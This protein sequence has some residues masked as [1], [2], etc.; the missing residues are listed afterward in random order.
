MA[1]WH[2]VSDTS[3]DLFTLEGGEGVF[4]FATIPFTIR[5]GETE[6]IDDD[7]MSVEEMLTANE[8]H[9]EM[10]QT[11]CPS[12]EDWRE[13]FEAPG[14]VL[15]FTISSAL[16]GSYNSACAAKAM[17]LEDEP[18]KQIA[19]IDSKGTG[20]EVAAAVL[21]ARE[22][23]LAGKSFDEIEKELNR[24]VEETHI[25]FALASYRNLIKAGRVSR[26]VGFI[27]GHLGFWGIGIGDEN[28]QIAMRGKARGDKSMVRQMVDEIKKIGL[29]FGTIRIHHCVNEEGAA[30]LMR[31]LKA[32]FPE[33][34]IAVMPTRGLDSFYAERRGLIVSF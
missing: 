26:L 10:A 16:S 25:V 15:A 4:D 9:A 24:T 8:N 11:S 28:G 30:A 23:V 29:A 34:G 22:M 1:V 32:A 27:A 21:R 12:P 13:K 14:P 19:V 5:I 7:T 33:A 20:P 2:I 3:C 17:I 18:D 31:S 6:Y